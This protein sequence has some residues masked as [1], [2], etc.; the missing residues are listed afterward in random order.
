MMKVL[1]VLAI[2]VAALGF[3]RGWF[4]L[5]SRSRDAESNKVNVSLTVDPDKMK[6]D[7]EKVEEKTAELTDNAAAQA[8]E[9]GDQAEGNLNSDGT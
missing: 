9:L 7:A 8:K 4:S 6:E 3:Y 5:S 2:C 1:V